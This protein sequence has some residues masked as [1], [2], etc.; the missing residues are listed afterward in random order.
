[1]KR[2]T[3]S[4][5]KRKTKSRITD[6]RRKFS[7]LNPM[8][9]TRV[10]S[11]SCVPD[12][13]MVKLKY[14]SQIKIDTTSAFFYDQIYRGNTLFDPDL[15]NV[16]HQPM[17]YDQWAAFYNRYR[18][19]ACAAKLNIINE[20]AGPPCH[21]VF[22]PSTSAT[23]Y[24]GDLQEALEQP[25][26]KY[27]GPLEVA[28]RRAHSMKHYM[29]TSEVFGV[30]AEAVKDENDYSAATSTSPNKIWYWHLSLVSTDVSSDLL[31][32]WNL[33]LTYY[34]MFQDR[35]ALANS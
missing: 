35:V 5:K 18:V 14:V 19:L 13:I 26:A 20:A 25:R 32:T 31:I 9:I 30:P 10:N 23:P 7:Q 24:S 22:G 34:C 27:V 21:V 33:E 3:T 12:A 2:R 15:T 28:S 1:M 4:K 16:G 17:G 8:H 11:V 29:T 6:G